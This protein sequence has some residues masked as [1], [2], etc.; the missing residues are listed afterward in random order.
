MIQSE[1]HD[2]V[3]YLLADAVELQKLLLRRRAILR[4]KPVKLQRAGRDSGRGVYDVRRAVAAAQRGEVGGLQSGQPLRRRERIEPL[5]LE[6]KLI[7]EHCAQALDDSLDAR[8][9]VTLR[10]DERTQRLPAV[11]PQDA[12]PAPELDAL[13]QIFAA[14]KAARGRGIVAVEVKIFAPQLIGRGGAQ[15]HPAVLRPH[16]RRIPEGDAGVDAVLVRVPA[17]A[18]PALKGFHYVKLVRASEI[19]SVY[20]SIFRHK[21]HRQDYKSQR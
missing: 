15:V 1:Q 14:V 13:R 5:S 17:E 7:P 8:D 3:R 10:D 2:A 16:P 20:F 9:V 12:Y 21:N 18:L 6:F 11:L 4:R 19:Q